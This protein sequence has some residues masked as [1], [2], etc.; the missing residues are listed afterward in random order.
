MGMVM[1]AAT[2]IAVAAFITMPICFM[3]GRSPIASATW[4]IGERPSMKQ[5]GM[6]MKAATAIAA[7]K[8]R[9]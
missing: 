2:A 1:K 4:A 7:D 6:V 8:E 9:L 5:M 3:D